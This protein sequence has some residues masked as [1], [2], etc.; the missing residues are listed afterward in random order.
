MYSCEI[1]RCAAH[2][3]AGESASLAFASSADGG[4]IERRY[5]VARRAR[6]T[7]TYSRCFIRRTDYSINDDV[8]PTRHNPNPVRA[9]L[10]EALRQAQGERVEA[11]MTLTELRYIVAVAREKHF[12]RAA[13]A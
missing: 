2:A 13:E 3:A 4:S 6:R 10:V 5:L 1:F 11:T 12:G 9:E 8:Q 7:L